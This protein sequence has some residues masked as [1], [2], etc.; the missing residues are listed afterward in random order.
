MND[1]KIEIQGVSMWAGGRGVGNPYVSPGFIHTRM[2]GG[3]ARIYI[4]YKE[5]GKAVGT[6]SLLLQKD[7]VIKLINGLKQIYNLEG[8]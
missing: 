6:A 3:V 5:N 8:V 2:D 4:E 7:E 1:T